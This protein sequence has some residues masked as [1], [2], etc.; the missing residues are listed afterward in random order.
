LQFFSTIAADN[1]ALAGATGVLSEHP[2]SR[3]AD[4]HAADSIRIATLTAGASR[5]VTGSMPPR[6]P[7]ERGGAKFRLRYGNFMATRG[8]RGGATWAAPASRP[9][10]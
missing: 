2:A 8:R 3:P 4:N 6:G 1:V 10:R 7:H 5:A 9:G